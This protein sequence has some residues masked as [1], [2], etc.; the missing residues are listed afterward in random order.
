MKL[1]IS[2]NWYFIPNLCQPDDDRLGTADVA[3][4]VGSR[5]TAS[6]RRRVQAAFFSFHRGFPRNVWNL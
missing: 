6:G 1:L 4:P 3:E 5:I 2:L